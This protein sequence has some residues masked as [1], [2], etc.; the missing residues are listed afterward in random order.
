[1]GDQLG[2]A[3]HPSVLGYTGCEWALFFFV[4]GDSEGVDMALMGMMRNCG[5]VHHSQL[6]FGWKLK[7]CH[8]F[9]SFFLRI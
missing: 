3:Q 4:K 8:P 2:H 5:A 9:W 7:V 6:L 1:M